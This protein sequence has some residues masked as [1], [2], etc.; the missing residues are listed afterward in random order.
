[1]KQNDSVYLC[2]FGV[3]PLLKASHFN[4]PPVFA[5]KIIVLNIL[6]SI[7]HT[8]CVF[9]LENHLQWLLLAI[10]IPLEQ[11]GTQCLGIAR[12]PRAPKQLLA[13]PAIFFWGPNENPKHK[14][15]AQ[16][17]QPHL[18]GPDDHI[19]LPGL[20]CLVPQATKQTSHTV[21]RKNMFLDNRANR[22][23]FLT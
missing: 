3:C 11:N 4:Q 1:M 21:V 20:P 16:N 5:H 13:V 9:H 15:L 2:L 10:K 14:C 8:S 18:S 17:Y 23:M 6:V 7:T 22:N 12:H 19:G